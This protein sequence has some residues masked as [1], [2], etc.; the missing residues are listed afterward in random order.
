M[1]MQSD[2][3]SLGDLFSDLSR[4]IATIVRKEIE[5]ARTEL[6]G[7]MSRIGAHA[8]VI[9]AGGVLALGG[10]LTLLAGIVL[11]LVRLGMPAWGA[12]LLVGFIVALVGGMMAQAA[13]KQLRSVDLTPHRT[14]RTMKENVQWTNVPTA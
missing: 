2:S 1:A 6:S 8:G 7:K 14:I 11:V 12:S 10:F 4:E 3:R 9:A 5:L 13:L